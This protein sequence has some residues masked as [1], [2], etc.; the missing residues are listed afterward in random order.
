M[1]DTNSLSSNPLNKIDIH[2]TIIG[3]GV[4][5]KTSITNR[6][7][8]IE[9]PEQ[10]DPTIEDKYN[11]VVNINSK[12]INLEILDTAG[13]QDYQNLLYSWITNGDAFI[14]VFAINDKESFDYL[15]KKREKIIEI[16]GNKNIPIILIGNKSDLNKEREVTIEEAEKISKLWNVD[17]VEC[18]AKNNT[19]CNN[20]INLL[21]NKWNKY[22]KDCEKNNK[23]NIGCRCIIF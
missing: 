17:Y 12:Q 11:L 7:I 8:N 2:I 9:Y 16:K 6:L 19:N 14:L 4:V 3:K 5:G 13:E 21:Y 18:S 22:L 15:L 23:D 1:K 20:I 10:H